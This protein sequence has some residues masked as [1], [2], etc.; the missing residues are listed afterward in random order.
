MADG[1][2]RIAFD[3]EE[4]KPDVMTAIFA[5][6]KATGAVYFIP[7]VRELTEEEEKY[8]N[9]VS[10]TLSGKDSPSRELRNMLYGYFKTLNPNGTPEEFPEFY[11]SSMR[12]LIDLIK[13]KKDAIQNGA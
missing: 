10:E 8:L 5:Q 12:T 13:Q 11:G 3:T 7:D 1:S 2:L 4:L 9:K 6:K